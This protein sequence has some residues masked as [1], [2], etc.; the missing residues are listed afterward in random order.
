[1]RLLTNNPIISQLEFII[2][3]CLW[4]EWE[5]L[6]QNVVVPHRR[7]VVLNQMKVKVSSNNSQ[8]HQAYIAVVSKFERLHDKIADMII[9]QAV[10]YSLT[11]IIN[12]QLYYMLTYKVCGLLKIDKMQ[13]C[14]CAIQ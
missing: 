8:H 7:Q 6:S 12:V 11:L 4:R 5:D 14:T 9:K 3:K 2:I 1:M 13:K 10:K